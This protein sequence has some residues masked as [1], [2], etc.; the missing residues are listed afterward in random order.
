[1]TPV[2]KILPPDVIGKI[3]AGEVIERP[4]SVVKELI[5]NSL[6]AKSSTIRVTI[7]GG[8]RNRI[9]VSDDGHG[10]DTEDAIRSME[11]HA[12]SKLAHEDDLC[13]ITT[14]GFRGEALPSIAAVSRLTL[15]TRLQDSST[16]I[17]IKA[18]GGHIVEAVET[19]APYGTR[20]EV[21]DLF[22]NLP[23]RR[24]FLRG[25]KTEAAHVIETIIRMALDRYTVAF[26]L[27]HDGRSLFDLPPTD[28]ELAR[29]RAVMGKELIR[30]LVPVNYSEGHYRISGWVSRPTLTKG[31][32]KGIY[33][34]VNGRYV[35][36]KILSHALSVAY[37]GLISPKTY[38]V[39]ILAVSIPFD[40]FDVNVHPAKLEIRFKHSSEVHRMVTHGLIQV[41]QAGRMNGPPEPEQQVVRE[42]KP[43]YYTGVTAV[44]PAP[45]EGSWPWRTVG[46]LMNTYLVLEHTEGVILL[47]QHAVHERV[48]YEQ[49]RSRGPVRLPQQR[50][51]IPQLCDMARDDIALL[52]EHQSELQTSGLELEEYG[53]RTI[54][55]TALPA[56]LQGQDITS[57]LESL[58]RQIAL[59]GRVNSVGDIGHTIATLVACRGAIKAGR[60]LDEAEVR[61]L[62]RQ[63]DALGRPTTCP[64]G[65]PLIKEWRWNDIE[66]W[67]NRS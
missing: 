17:R 16:G 45:A 43:A 8:G 2:I 39:A 38:P 24:K 22:Y 18:E 49:L 65:R 67:F 41:L 46:Q 27:I 36:D 32:A 4:A 48:L 1:M 35:R 25:E 3:A 10:M 61:A 40:E 53:P 44:A 54:A 51:L 60:R 9:V 31:S 52:L 20:V 63:W 66:R 13:H 29:I 37:Q 47:D 34:Y 56:V 50:L 62:L 19:G 59:T 15:T 14:L 12:T 42:E 6:D 26:R 21:D 55:V 58:S 57:F 7:E 11:R 33:T 30:H 28:Q 5:E 23:A 64:H